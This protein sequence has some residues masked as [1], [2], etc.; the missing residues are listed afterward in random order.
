MIPQSQISLAVNEARAEKRS[1]WRSRL[2]KL[3]AGFL[4]GCLWSTLLFA[5]HPID[6]Q[7]LSAEGDHFKAL[8]LYELLPERRLAEDTRIAAAKSAW[9]LGLTKKAC[10]LFDAVLRGNSIDTDERARITLS[11]GVIDF[12]EGRYQEAALFSEKAAGL[13]PERAPLRG[14]ALL[15]W[16][17]SLLKAQAYASAEEK[18]LRALGEVAPSDRPD[19]AL[20]LGSVQI[21]LGKLSDAE[22]F[23]KTIP[24]THPSA[25]EA[26]R[27]LASI[28]L[29]TKQ[30]ERARF[31]IEKGKST[32]SDA[33]LDSWPDYGLAKVAIEANDLP[34]ARSVVD[35]AS[36]RFPPS[37][38]W[39]ILMKA[40]LEQAEWS[41]RA[42]GY[43]E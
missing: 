14:R 37:D 40:A 8:T 30:N 11:R 38:P 28:A 22:R 21:K 39:L 33:F 5:E 6:V 26:I 32:Y 27:M 29:Q 15:L 42:K 43:R 16:G 2:L 17:Q 19:V 13:L 18:L 25:S 41:E 12:Q 4:M 31:W 1:Q 3:G 35:R 36:Q 10:G 23:V 20:L 7:R 34:Q 9:A 24:A